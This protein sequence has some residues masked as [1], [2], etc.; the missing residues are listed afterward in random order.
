MSMEAEQPAEDKSTPAS[1]TTKSSAE[2]WGH[3]VMDLGFCVVPSLLLRAQR[4]LNL[5]PTQLAVLLQLCDFWWDK[6][7]KPFPSKET[8]SQRLSLSERQ[9]Q[10]YIAEL[11]KEGLVQ[12]I[13]R[14]A[15]N[16]GK[17]SNTYDLT[18]LVK[19]LQTLEPD[20]REA[21]ETA[22][23]ARKAVT[24]RGYKSS[25]TPATSKEAAA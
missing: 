2:K 23:A 13:E 12:R 6:E 24:K 10:R 15:S 7:R 19:K 3:A 18:G 5:S 14:R 22:R 16:G 20:F 1:K 21:E 9:I 25:K 11:E 4:R 8:L 17:L